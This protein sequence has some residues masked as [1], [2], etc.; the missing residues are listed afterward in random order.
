MLITFVKILAWAFGASS[1]ALLILRLI[2]LYEYAYSKR[3]NL[4]QIKDLV[5]GRTTIFPLT[6]PS[7]VFIVSLAALISVW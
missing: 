4:Y 3:A 7:I 2:G 5:N 6:I 1:L